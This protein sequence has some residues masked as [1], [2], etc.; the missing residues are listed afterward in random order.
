MTE[1]HFMP[2]SLEI[3]G[4]TELDGGVEYFLINVGL[5]VEIDEDV[6]AGSDE[7]TSEAEEYD[8]VV[9]TSAAAIVNFGTS[10][11]ICV[12]ET[13]VKDTG[14]AA[15][16]TSGTEETGVE[17][18]TVVVG[19]T[20]VDEET[21]VDGWAEENCMDEET[22]VTR[23]SDFLDSLEVIGLLASIQGMGLDAI[24]EF[25]LCTGLLNPPS[26]LTESNLPD[27]CT[28]T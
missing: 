11:D 15:G 25:L 5:V 3:T 7:P 21:S 17:E 18:D 24:T 20:G 16:T 23:I 27:N 8:L 6:K 22:S 26:S 13:T 19:E 2:W 28:S 14:V 1:T 9:E 12:A 4:G 10:M